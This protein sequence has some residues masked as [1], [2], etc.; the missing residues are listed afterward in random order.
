[1]KLISTRKIMK[2]TESRKTANGY[3]LK[4][5][6]QLCGIWTGGLSGGQVRRTVRPSRGHIRVRVRVGHSTFQTVAPPDRR[7]K[8]ATRAWSLKDHARRMMIVDIPPHSR[9][10]HSIES[11]TEFVIL[12]QNRSSSTEGDSFE[13]LSEISTDNGTYRLLILFCLVVVF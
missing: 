10:C 4:D 3:N 8:T 13:L 1:L 11:K 7:N 12:K 5:K 6:S 2:C 9:L